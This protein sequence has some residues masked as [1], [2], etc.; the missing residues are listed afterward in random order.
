MIVMPNLISR[1]ENWC[2][3][4]P[5]RR[6]YGVHSPSDFYL[7]TSVIYEKLPFYAYQSLHEQRQ[8]TGTGYREKVD[9]LLFRLANHLQPRTWVNDVDEN[10]C[11]GCYIE[12]ACPRLRCCSVSQ[13][14]TGHVCPDLVHLGSARYEDTFNR[15]LPW[16][17]N[18][19]VFIVGTPYATKEKE[20]WWKKVI[21]NPQVGVTFDLYDIGLVFFDK[22]R[23]KEHRIVNFF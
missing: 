17:G 18:R 9:R 10:H 20:Q 1:V 2:R 3:R 8:A 22:K 12:A 16:V 5:Y 14:E 4:F 13:V 21:A 23:C 7:I 15:L 19:T 6:G 11:T